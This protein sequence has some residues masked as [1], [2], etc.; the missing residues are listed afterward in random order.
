M[1]RYFEGFCTLL[2]TLLLLTSLYVAL[3]FV[4]SDKVL[5]TNQISI[6]GFAIL[7]AIVM[8][9]VRV[10][11]TLYGI[12]I[13]SFEDSLIENCILVISISMLSLT[14]RNSIYLDA[15]IIPV[16]LLTLGYMLRSRTITA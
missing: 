16:G 8:S 11:A 14:A 2:Y 13:R 10:R 3:S 5:T 1:S 7:M 15:V 9:V 4:D 6:F 12:T